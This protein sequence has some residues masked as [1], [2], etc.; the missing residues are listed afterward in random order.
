MENPQLLQNIQEQKE[1]IASHI[2]A[3]LRTDEIYVIPVVVHVVWNT[4]SQNIED[5][6]IYSQLEVLNRDFRKLNADTINTP[7]IFSEVASDAKITFCLA[8]VDP[9]GEATTGITRTFTENISFST[10]NE[11]KQTENGGIDPWDP[12]SYLNIWVCNLPST[13]LGYSSLPG[14]SAD[15][16][17]VVINYRFFGNGFGAV[18]PYNLGRTCT[19]EIGHYLGL[20]HIW[21]DDGG[22]CSND[23]G[24]GDTPLQQEETY[25]CP[26]FPLT[27]ACSPDFPGIMFMNYMDY[28]DDNCMN[29]FTEIQIINMRSTM[30]TIR[31]SLLFSPAGCN[32]IEPLPDG[33]AELLVNPNPATEGITAIIKNFDGSVL[34]VY[35]YTITGQLIE[36]KSVNPSNFSSAYFATDLLAP[37]IYFI[38]VFNGTYTLAK[39]F[40]V[41]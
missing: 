17:G 9:D 34:D 23:D 26:E 10:G 1:T 20:S 16:D 11:I 2:N 35:L 28:T 7:E 15:Q 25:G 29:L 22:T 14:F 21:G 8:S 27:D 5:D 32:E 3:Q 24:I 40:I 36:A 33:N 6:R 13:I 38:K 18:S 31:G 30:E 19:H 39:Q 37:G 4:E 12:L 41:M